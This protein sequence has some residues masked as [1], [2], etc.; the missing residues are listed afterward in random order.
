MARKDPAI[1]IRVP[2]NFLELIDAHLELMGRRK[3]RR[4]TRSSWIVAAINCRL[5]DLALRQERRGKVRC[6]R[7]S[8]MVK[9][10]D[11]VIYENLLLGE[12]A[13]TCKKCFGENPAF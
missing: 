3:G 6:C 1:S 13:Y 11:I 12:K 4:W 10:T 9:R 8:K 7:C 5:R 2:S